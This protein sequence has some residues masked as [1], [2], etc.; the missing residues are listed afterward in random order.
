[1][2]TT[3][4]KSGLKKP[5][6]TDELYQFVQSVLNSA[7]G[8]ADSSFR[9]FS[10]LGWDVSAKDFITGFI[11]SASTS[12]EQAS[13][14]NYL[15]NIFKYIE[16]PEN[17]QRANEMFSNEPIKLEGNPTKDQMYQAVKDFV[18]HNIEENARLGYNFSV[19]D[20]S[21]KGIAKN[22]SWLKNI[23]DKKLAQVQGKFVSKGSTTAPFGDPEKFTA[24]DMGIDEHS[25]DFFDGMHEKIQRLLND[26][27]KKFDALRSANLS[28]TFMGKEGASGEIQKM[29]SLLADFFITQQELKNNINLFTDTARNY[30]D[31]MNR[32]RFDS[33]YSTVFHPS[34]EELFKSRDDI[35]SPTYREITKINLPSKDDV[36]DRTLNAVYN[37]LSRL[38]RRWI[39]WAH[40][41]NDIKTVKKSSYLISG[42]AEIAAATQLHDVL[43]AAYFAISNIPENLFLRESIQT[44]LKKTDN[45]FRK[46]FG[47]DLKD[48]AKRVTLQMKDK[49]PGN[50]SEMA[51]WIFDNMS[52]AEAGIAK[53]RQT[54]VESST[55]DEPGYEKNV[56]NI[57]GEDNVS[58]KANPY[59][60][61]DG[62]TALSDDGSKAKTWGQMLDKGQLQELHDRGF[63]VS[64]DGDIVDTKTGEIVTDPGVID[65]TPTFQ[66]RMMEAMTPSDKARVE[67]DIA[68]AQKHIEDEYEQLPNGDVVHKPSGQVFE[69]H[70]AFSFLKDNTP[71]LAGRSR[72][73]ILPEVRDRSLPDFKC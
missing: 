34:A 69:K 37:H 9:D 17:F 31:D 1:M 4:P 7:T 33:R 24:A 50:L 56:D 35:T 36:L 53:P 39:T 51:E 71:R 60:S 44:T 10:K 55:M 43:N 18:F 52:A 27:A 70:E 30:F 21:F 5:S 28:K 57:V 48:I 11:E 47:S 62:D 67:S 20:D 12:A 29:G 49:V 68:L 45:E 8:S 19:E 25:K 32:N 40:A 23:D 26:A 2:P 59:F 66:Q 63:A 38:N 6:N 61:M 54:S 42:S 41:D 73:T 14:R 13:R 22:I 46:T 64:K 58:N 72:T 65:Q 3:D 15:T 16:K